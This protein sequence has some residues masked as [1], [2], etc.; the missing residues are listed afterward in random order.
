MIERRYHR[1]PRDRAE[2]NKNPDQLRACLDQFRPNLV[3]NRPKVEKF[4]FAPL[5][6]DFGALRAHIC[7]RFQAQIGDRPTA[8][9]PNPTSAECRPTDRRTGRRADRPEGA[10]ESPHIVPT[11]GRCDRWPSQAHH[12]A[13][14]APEGERWGH[15]GWWWGRDDGSRRRGSAAPPAPAA[16]Q[17]EVGRVSR[18]GVCSVRLL[19]KGSIKGPRVAG[20]KSGAGAAQ[21]DPWAL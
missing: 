6:P 13:E 19:S 14:A 1:E 11:A 12:S 15:Q 8:G 16:R 18:G 10:T 4:R 17:L 20:P 9:P 5:W 3:W 21:I 2:Q 7:G